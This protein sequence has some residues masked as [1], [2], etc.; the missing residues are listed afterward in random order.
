MGEWQNFVK[1]FFI[2]ICTV[3]LL[4]YFQLATYICK[5]VC[6]ATGKHCAADCIGKLNMQIERYICIVYT[7]I[8]SNH[9]YAHTQQQQHLV[10]AKLKKFFKCQRKCEF[11]PK[12]SICGMLH[13]PAYICTYIYVYMWDTEIGSCPQH[14]APW[15]ICVWASAVHLY[16]KHFNTLFKH[17]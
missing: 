15:G 3:W 4:L 16:G 14:E 2:Y 6:I 9:L 5:C 13:M 17:A 7:H 10:V 1:F 11:N 8:Y 12:T